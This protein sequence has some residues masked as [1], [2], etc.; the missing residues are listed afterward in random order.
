[1]TLPVT[2]T[3]LS[4]NR[5]LHLW[6]SLDSLYRCTRYPHRFVMIDMAS[7]DPLVPRVIAG[8]A[9]RGL[10]SQV[11]R[12]PCNHPQEFWKVLWT[13][14]AGGGKFIGHVDADVVV[15]DSEPC[16]LGSFVDLMERNTNLAMVGPT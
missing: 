7:D 6:A 12:A 13:L 5:P 1:M 15:E 2:V 11:I 8:F 10:F 9:R 4:H 16:W 3:I 14:V